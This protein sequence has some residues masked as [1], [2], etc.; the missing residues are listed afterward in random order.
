MP[1]LSPKPQ[2]HPR[3]SSHHRLA[4]T[5]GDPA[6]IGPEVALMAMAECA[7]EAR[8]LL[9]GPEALWNGAAAK[10]GT[11]RPDLRDGVARALGTAE[12]ADTG[13]AGSEAPVAPGATS[14]RC[15]RIAMRAIER[16]VELARSGE[17]DA[18]VT[19]PI[20]K[21]G[22]HLAGAEWPGHTEM[23]RDLCGAADTTMAFRGG[24]LTMALATI[25]VPLREVFALLTPELIWRKAAHLHAF[26]KMLLGREPVIGVAGLN[27]HASEGGLFGDEE[28]AVIE[29]AIARA[30]A[31]G[32]RLT[33]PWP[34]DTIFHEALQGTMD[35]VLALYHDQGLIALKTLAFD[36]SVNV[37]L[38]LPI[39]RTSPDH[40]TA[41]GIAGKGTAR[42][43][44]MVAAVRLAAELA[45]RRARA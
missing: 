29:P 24:G 42:P 15:G 14:E 3:K 28:A 9:V 7:S 39:V 18:I 41:F 30:N 36:S 10:L 4:I 11:V 45:E 21:E 19:A 6:G 16:A 35:G 26:L 1:T 38:G 33:G 25:H 17:V 2:P 44:S 43:G 20:S 8:F 5:I 23:L 12:I 31:E 22:L 40:G 13:A 32:L 34:P 27:P 37:T